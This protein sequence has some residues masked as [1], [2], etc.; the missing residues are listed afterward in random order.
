MEILI[1]SAGLLGA[2]LILGAYALLQLGRAH[3]GQASF[4]LMNLV[5]SVLLT[6]VAV[7]DL[8]WGFIILETAWAVLS[9]IGLLRG[10]STTGVAERP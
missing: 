8:R 5:G 10:G 7:V 9:L 4:N 6:I 2:G 3:R 1:Q